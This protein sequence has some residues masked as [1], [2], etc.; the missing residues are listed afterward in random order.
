MAKT[1]WKQLVETVKCDFTGHDP[2]QVEGDNKESCGVMKDGV[3]RISPVDSKKI[4]K[5]ISEDM[6]E[7]IEDMLK[8]YSVAATD[9]HAKKNLLQ[10]LLA[11]FTADKEELLRNIGAAAEISKE[12]DK[13]GMRNTHNLIELEKRGSN[14]HKGPRVEQLRAVLDLE[15]T[16]KSAERNIKLTDSV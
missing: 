10:K 6:E 8:R 14:P 9:K 5:Y 2:N 16:L 13:K 1:V 7:T 15:K 11:E 3:C 12:L 4:C